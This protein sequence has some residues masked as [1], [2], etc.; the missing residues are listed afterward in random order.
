MPQHEIPSAFLIRALARHEAQHCDRCGH[1]M[2]VKGPSGLCPFCL[3]DRP[4]RP[5]EHR[6]L[7][8][9]SSEPFAPRLA[10]TAA[11]QRYPL[12][13]RF[14]SLVARARGT[15]KPATGPLVS[16]PAHAEASHSS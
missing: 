5:V 4:P 14:R 13:R 7:P 16:L 1:R 8:A 12:R 3:S 2:F 15:S 10:A 11:W 6:A 9:S